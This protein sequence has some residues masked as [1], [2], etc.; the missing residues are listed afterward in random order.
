[1]PVT[2]FTLLLLKSKVDDESIL[3]QDH[4][5]SNKL[6]SIIRIL[7]PFHYHF[8][9][10]MN[11]IKCSLLAIIFALVMVQAKDLARGFSDKINWVDGLAK[12][13]RQT[14]EALRHLVDN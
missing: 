14:L 10:K 3:T 9:L 2:S 13:S 7:Y 11:L 6:T 5:P 12:V 1:M 8:Y 4:V